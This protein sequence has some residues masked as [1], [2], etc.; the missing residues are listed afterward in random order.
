MVLKFQRTNSGLEPM[1]SETSNLW[2]HW[3]HAICACP[4]WYS[5]QWW[6]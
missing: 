2:N 6:T 3:I 4:K 1:S 5:R